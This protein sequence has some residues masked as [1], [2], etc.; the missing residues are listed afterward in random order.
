MTDSHLKTVRLLYSE[1]LTGEQVGQGT[2]IWHFFE[3][4]PTLKVPND[5]NVELN[6]V[7]SSVE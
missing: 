7:L 6:Q 1:P 4:P 2:Q 3:G 5:W